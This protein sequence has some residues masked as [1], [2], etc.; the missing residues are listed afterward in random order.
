[1]AR[2]PRIAAGTPAS[3]NGP[4]EPIV[5]CNCTAAE[6]ARLRERVVAAAQSCS[7]R[8]VAAPDRRSKRFVRGLARPGK[9]DETCARPGRTDGG[10]LQSLAD[11]SGSALTTEAQTSRSSIAITR[12][13]SGETT[14]SY[15]E[16][17][18]W[19]LRAGPGPARCLASATY[20]DA[21]SGA[22]AAV[23]WQLARL[24]GRVADRLGTWCRQRIADAAH[25][26]LDRKGRAR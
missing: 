14:G 15:A 16:A 19:P 10:V 1:M 25:S 6:S 9:P 26:N 7:V 24:P 22:A 13:D 12:E 18:L 23:D 5:D 17:P 8:A 20:S 4:H 2:V 11:G 21:T 3:V